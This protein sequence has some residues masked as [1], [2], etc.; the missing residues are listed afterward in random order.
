MSDTDDKNPEAKS[1]GALQTGS[2]SGVAEGKGSG[3]DESRSDSVEPEL[4]EK[5]IGDM[6]PA[7]RQSVRTAM[8]GFSASGPMPHPLLSKFNDEHIHKFLDYV[9]KDDENNFQ[10]RSSNRWFSLIYTLLFLGLFVFL[11]VFLLPTDKEIL[12]DLLKLIVAFA[13]GVGGGFGLKTYL[14]KRP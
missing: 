5:M 10:I 9:Q 3:S 2:D 8:L 13:G 4:V 12:V 7:V 14:D 6:P 11:I 1:D